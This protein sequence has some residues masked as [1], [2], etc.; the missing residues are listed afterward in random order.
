MSSAVFIVDDD[1][2]ALESLRWLIEQAGLRV[3]A[4]RSSR[5]FLEFYGPEETG[6]LLLD[7]R[8]PEIDGLAVQEILRGARFACRSSLFRRTVMCRRVRAPSVEGGRFSRKTGQRQ[9]AAAAHRKAHLS[10]G[11]SSRKQ[12]GQLFRRPLEPAHANRNRDFD[13]VDRGQEHQGDRPGEKGFRSDCLAASD[14]HFSKGRCGKSRRTGPCRYPVAASTRT[15]SIDCQLLRVA[16]SRMRPG[17]GSR[18]AT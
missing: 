14:E 4:F 7:V 8:M 10:A 16:C 5:E 13:A 1:P 18:H 12:R 9:S 17:A 2:G 3:K 11:T 15:T 6:C